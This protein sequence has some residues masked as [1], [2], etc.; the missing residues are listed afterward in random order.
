MRFD[1]FVKSLDM[2]VGNE[3]EDIIAN[4]SSQLMRFADITIPITRRDVCL[5]I[6]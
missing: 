5:F 4:A 1:V 6:I 2:I 3:V